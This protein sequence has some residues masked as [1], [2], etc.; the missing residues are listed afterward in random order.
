MIYRKKTSFF[1][2]EILSIEITN[3][4]KNIILSSV[5]RPPDSILKDF[6]SSLKLIF[7]K[8]RRNNKNLYLVG[9]FNINVRDYENNVKVKDFC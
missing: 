3:Q 6:K 5:D 4:T 1:D 2:G 7:D 9:D 8:I